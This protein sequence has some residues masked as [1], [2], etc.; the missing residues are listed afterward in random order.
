MVLLGGGWGSFAFGGDG[1]EGGVVG[2]VRNGLA[3]EVEGQGASFGTG[4]GAFDAGEVLAGGGELAVE[5]GG[6]VEFDGLGG[7]EAEE[8]GEA[9]LDGV[10][11]ERL[12]E[13]GA[14][15][16][17]EDLLLDGTAGGMVVEAELLAA[18]GGGAALVAIGEEVAAGA[19]VA[20]CGHRASPQFGEW[21]KC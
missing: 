21:I 9:A 3:I 14:G 2:V 15:A 8:F 19:E 16:A 1:S 17:V 4:F 20:G 13:G 18:Q 12:G 6:G 10:E 5:L 7:G 11:V